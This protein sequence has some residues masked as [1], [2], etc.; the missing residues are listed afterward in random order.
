M[1]VEEVFQEKET[2]PGRCDP[3]RHWLESI[4]GSRAIEMVVLV[5]LHADI[6]MPF[7]LDEYRSGR[8]KQL[9]PC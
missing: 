7:D 5:R 4:E 1:S 8:I 2:G 6:R 9:C 3:V